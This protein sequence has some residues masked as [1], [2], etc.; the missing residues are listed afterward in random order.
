MDEDLDV[1]LLKVEGENL[2]HLPLRISDAKEHESIYV[3]GNPLT[4]TQIVNEGEIVNN[5]QPYQ[6][7]K[8]TNPIF[9]GHS[10]SPVISQAGEVVGIVYARMIPSIG[11]QEEGHDGKLGVAL[12]ISKTPFE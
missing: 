1:A 4:Q 11:S 12:E 10:G 9:P 8:I 6:V 3:I 7:M 2:P 5:E